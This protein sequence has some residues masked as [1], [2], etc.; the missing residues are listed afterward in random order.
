MGVNIIE[1][2]KIDDRP[3]TMKLHLCKYW[4]TCTSGEMCI[5]VEEIGGAY[6][7]IIHYLNVH[8]LRKGFYNLEI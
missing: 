5:K 4:K 8:L 2:T 1:V 6:D 7:G 3:C